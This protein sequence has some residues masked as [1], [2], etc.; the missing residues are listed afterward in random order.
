ME[1]DASRG[2][3]SVFEDLVRAALNLKTART[4]GIG[5]GV[6]GLVTL[7]DGSII[8]LPHIPGAEGFSPPPSTA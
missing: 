8:T 2:F 3:P 1:T 6:P 5:I 7:A 4:A